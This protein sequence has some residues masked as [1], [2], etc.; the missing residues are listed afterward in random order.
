VRFRDTRIIERTVIHEDY[1]IGILGEPMSL[2]R[3]LRENPPII[4]IA[5]NFALSVI[6]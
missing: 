2:D 4:H 5:Y 3:V 1:P 6:E